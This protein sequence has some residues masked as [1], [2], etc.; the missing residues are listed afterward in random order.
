MG[1]ICCCE[2]VRCQWTC[3]KQ[4]NRM[5]ARRFE[6][7]TQICWWNFVSCLHLLAAQTRPLLHLFDLLKLN[8]ISC[9]SW[10]FGS[11]QCVLRLSLRPLQLLQTYTSKNPG[12]SQ[13]SPKTKNQKA[14]NYSWLKEI[15][16]IQLKYKPNRGQLC[17]CLT[18]QYPLVEMW[19]RS[20][21]APLPHVLAVVV[22]VLT[23]LD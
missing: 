12:R 4:N 22:M 19:E 16:M 7:F 2:T 8:S 5:Q 11:R 15:K 9:S 17:K 3:W 10:C 1:W 14:Q 6:L 13:K 23:V 18:K 20:I 21:Y